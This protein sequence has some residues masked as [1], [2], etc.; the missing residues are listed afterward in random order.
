MADDEHDT[1]IRILGL[2]NGGRTAYDG[3]YV[4]DYD[5]SR[6][7]F[8][9]G[10]GRPMMC[11]LVATPDRAKATRYRR[12]RHGFQ[13]VEGRLMIARRDQFRFLQYRYTFGDVTLIVQKARNRY[14]R[15]YVLDE[16]GKYLSRG[17]DSQTAATAAASGIAC[18]IRAARAEAAS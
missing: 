14:S 2:V 8:E 10:T 18:K 6:Q 11:H 5:A 13:G 12:R 7:G 4:V 1:L 17:H 16:N 9:Q 15:W 3:Q